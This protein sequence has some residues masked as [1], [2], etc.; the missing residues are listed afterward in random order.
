M[1]VGRSDNS[2]WQSWYKTTRPV[3]ERSGTSRTVTGLIPGHNSMA[4]NLLSLVVLGCLCAVSS[5]SLAAE[6]TTTQPATAPAATSDTPQDAPAEADDATTVDPKK[7]HYYLQIIQSPDTPLENRIL[8]TEVLLS[9]RWAEGNR[10][11]VLLLEDPSDTTCRVAVASALAREI[12]PDPTF[13]DPLFNALAADH[14]PLQQAAAEALSHYSN[15]GVTDRLIQ[16]VTDTKAA[17]PARLSGISALA[18]TGTRAATE[19][20]VARVDDPLRA[21]RVAAMSGLQ[22]NT[23]TDFGMNAEQWRTWWSQHK[24]KSDCEWLAYRFRTSRIRLHRLNTVHRDTSRQ[25]TAALVDLY[26]RRAASNEQLQMDLLG[27]HLDAELPAVKLAALKIIG[28]YLILHQQL[29]DTLTPKLLQLAEDNDSSVRRE[30]TTILGD[31]RTTDAVPILLRRLEVE[32]ARDTLEAILLA[33]GKTGGTDVLPALLTHVRSPAPWTARA[34]ASA[35]ARLLGRQNGNGSNAAELSDELR[36]QAVATLRERF[37]ETSTSQDELRQNLIRAMAAIADPSCM[38]L[39]ASVLADSNDPELR[40]TAVKGLVAL[41]KPEAADVLAGALSDQSPGVRAEIADGLGELGTT[42]SHITALL[43]RLNTQNES[44]TSVQDKAWQAVL[45]ILDRRAAGAHLDFIEANIQQIT[46]AKRAG[47]LLSRFHARLTRETN[48]TQAERA[49]LCRRLALLFSKADRWSES[50]VLYRSAYDALEQGKPAQAADIAILVVESLV[51]AGKSSEAAEFLAVA[52][53]RFDTAHLNRIA[54]NLAK[55][56]TD[57]AGDNAD[58]RASCKAAIHN[59]FLAALG[60]DARSALITVWQDAPPVG[61]Q[62]PAT[63][64]ADTQPAK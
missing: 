50:A 22:Q 37:A 10:K 53:K 38:T 24:D 49:T 34:S 33:L 15:N 58:R 39:F 46:P 56:L 20:L 57:Y 55:R 60:N 42:D 14:A 27:P 51:R 7:L 48:T 23:Q 16:L 26:R 40:R 12:E 61:E 41:R 30:A 3:A 29:P 28:D 64:P 4:T 11:L 19:A 47:E 62:Q 13:I 17:L 25:L 1:P 52:G 8:T 43:G 18:M 45:A 2:D 59:D 5:Q 44:D 36:T 32:P 63:Q 35:L 31:T 54:T 9:E 21:I 6:A